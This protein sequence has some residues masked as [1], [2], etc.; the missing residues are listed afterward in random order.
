MVSDKKD[1]ILNNWEGYDELRMKA[2]NAKH[3]YGNDDN[4][5]KPPKKTL[6]NMY[7]IDGVIFSCCV[8]FLI[9]ISPHPESILPKSR[10]NPCNYSIIRLYYTA[11]IT[12]KQQ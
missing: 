4:Y 2:L 3:K 5:P 11:F 12:E 7:H 1:A 6:E 10:G 9:H 8:I